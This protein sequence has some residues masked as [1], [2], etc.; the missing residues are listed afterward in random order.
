MQEVILSLNIYCSHIKTSF[1]TL[2]SVN[3]SEDTN[4]FIGHTFVK[5]FFTFY[6]INL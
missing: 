3:F 1:G 2:R 5:F 6:I 4:C